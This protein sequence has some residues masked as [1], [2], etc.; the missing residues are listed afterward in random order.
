M[1][2][3]FYQVRYVKGP[4][5]STTPPSDQSP[6][7]SKPPAQLPRV[8]S[9]IATGTQDAGEEYEMCDPATPVQKAIE[10]VFKKERGPTPKVP[11]PYLQSR[12]LDRS[13]RHSVSLG[14]N[15]SCSDLESS[16]RS[17]LQEASSPGSLKPPPRRKFSI[18]KPKTNKKQST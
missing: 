18:H 9:A 17:P 1:K 15:Y 2:S 14:R 10:D 4:M 8:M 3:N 13:G 6:N 7:T 11:V 16:P 5:K 12:S